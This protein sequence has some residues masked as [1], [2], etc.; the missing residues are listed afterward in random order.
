MNRIVDGLCN[1]TSEGVSEYQ[2]NNVYFNLFNAFQKLANNNAEFRYAL[3]QFIVKITP[4][5]NESVLS[6]SI[7]ANLHRQ[8]QAFIEKM[9]TTQL[10]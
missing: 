6:H 7:N 5:F 9:I 3:S 8:Y 2:S 10:K 4:Q 1:S